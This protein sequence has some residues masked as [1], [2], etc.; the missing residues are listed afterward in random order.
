MA[1]WKIGSIALVIPGR[2]VIALMLHF[3]LDPKWMLNRRIP[4]HGLLAVL[5]ALIVQL[6]V[7]AGVPRADPMAALAGVDA[8]CHTTGQSGDAPAQAPMHPADCLVCPLCVAVHLPTATLVAPTS[9]VMPPAV[10]VVQRH[11]LPPPAT[12]P[13]FPRL[14]LNQPRAPPI[15]S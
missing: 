10:V 14:A 2:V 1:M 3:R 12:A 11:E 9:S 4:L 8:I 6:G 15:D 13:P 7:G 5:M